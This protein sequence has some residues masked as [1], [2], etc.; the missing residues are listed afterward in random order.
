LIPQDLFKIIFVKMFCSIFFV[1]IEFCKFW[2][3]TQTVTR[4]YKRSSANFDLRTNQGNEKQNKQKHSPS[5]L[6]ERWCHKK[7]V[8]TLK[9]RSIDSCFFRCRMHKISSFRGHSNNK[10]PYWHFNDHSVGHYNYYKNNCF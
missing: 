6:L 4:M 9:T 3:V 1:Q 2:N 5:Y 10:W 7:L 8:V